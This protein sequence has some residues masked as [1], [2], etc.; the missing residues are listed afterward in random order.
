MATETAKLF[1]QLRRARL[2]PLPT[3]RDL[4]KL[5]QLN[6]IKQLSQN[7]L[8]DY[9]LTGKIC[10]AAGNLSDCLVCEVGPGPGGITRSILERL[11]KKVIVIEKDKRFERSLQILQQ[12]CPGKL[13]IYWGDVLS[14]NMKELIPPEFAKSWEEDSLPKLHLIGNLPFNIAT[15]LISR[16]LSQISRKESIW[17]H[18]RVPMTLTFQKEV[19]ERLTAEASTEQRSRLSI[20]AQ[21]LTH[22]TLKF[23]MKGKLINQNIK[24]I[25]ARKGFLCESLIYL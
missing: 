14:F 1:Q 17:E 22:P 6:A 23:V 2:P 5:Y 20:M 12:A 11:P 8:L 7:F 13:D 10:K 9:K 19:A 15:P 21:Y 24:S 3:V 4:V 25:A 18:G 16:W